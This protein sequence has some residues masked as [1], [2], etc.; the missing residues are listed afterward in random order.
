MVIECGEQAFLVRGRYERRRRA[1]A[2]GAAH[3]AEHF[4]IVPTLSTFLDVTL[5]TVSLGFV[6]RSI[7]VPG[8]QFQQLLMVY[9]VLQLT[10]SSSPCESATLAEACSCSLSLRLA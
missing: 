8:E 5:D 1:A 9:C 10:H 7:D 4:G 6:E 2:H 3:I